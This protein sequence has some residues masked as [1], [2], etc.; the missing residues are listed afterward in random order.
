MTTE[1]VV[2][3]NSVQVDTTQIAFVDHITG[4]DSIRYVSTTTTHKPQ[5]S[6]TGIS[7]LEAEFNLV[8]KLLNP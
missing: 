6:S 1:I 4:E 2:N 8:L 5:Y 7:S 3:G